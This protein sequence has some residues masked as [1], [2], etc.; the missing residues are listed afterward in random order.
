MRWVIAIVSAWGVVAVVHAL[1]A[2][3]VVRYQGRTQAWWPT[4]GYMG[5]IYSVW[6]VL[7]LPIAHIALRIEN[8]AGPLWMRLALHVAIWPVVVML[9]TLLFV[10]I[11]WPVYRSENVPTHRAMA[12][13]MLVQ[14][15]DTGSIFYAAI[16]CL[17]IARHRMRRAATLTRTGGDATRAASAD[18]D[19]LVVR[20]RGAIHRI[21]LGAVDWIGA[22]GDYA[23]IHSGSAVQLLEESLASLTERLPGDAFARIHR[24]ALVRRDRIVRVEPLGRG[25]ARVVLTTGETLR[26]SR[27]YRSNLAGLLGQARLPA[28]RAP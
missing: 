22:A 6:A 14:N 16:V 12:E 17:V 15:F 26:L 25:D 18:G 10:L 24:G 11:Y 23:E 3:L 20:T 2:C 9:H 21:P 5:A 1:L 13:T 7:T 27:R 8:R 19:A 4:L 28:Q